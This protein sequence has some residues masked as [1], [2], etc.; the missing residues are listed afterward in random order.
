MKVI[1]QA[2]PEVLLI[3]PARFGDARGFFSE[4]WKRSA[5]EAQGFAAD[6]VGPAAGVVQMVGTG[7][8][9]IVGVQ[10]GW[11][12]APRLVVSTLDHVKQ[13]RIDAVGDEALAE[14]V[15]IHAPGIGSAVGEVLKNAASGVDAVDAAVA[16]DA[17]LGGGAPHPC[18]SPLG[19]EG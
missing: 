14:V 8:Q 6:F 5:L 3:E 17:L 13:V 9:P 16:V 19:E 15:E 12:I 11:P 4:V 10:T 2:I 18:P 7:R 1:P